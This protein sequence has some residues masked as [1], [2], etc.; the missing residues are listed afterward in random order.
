[1]LVCVCVWFDAVVASFLL[2]FCDIRIRTH[3]QHVFCPLSPRKGHV[4]AESIYS[5]PLNSPPPPVFFGDIHTYVS[6]YV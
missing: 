2:L 5:P 4:G 6:M 1:M 3:E